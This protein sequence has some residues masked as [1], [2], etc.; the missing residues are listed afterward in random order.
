MAEIASW[1]IIFGLVWILVTTAQVRVAKASGYP[2]I[3]LTGPDFR[4]QAAR[5]GAERRVFE[6]P[7]SASIR[8]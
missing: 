1:L 7:A 2:T 6:T 5:F 3:N 4:F 8:C